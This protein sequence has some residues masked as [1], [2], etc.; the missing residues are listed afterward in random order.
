MKEQAMLV[1]CTVPNA[2]EA[3]SISR[4]LIRKKLAACCNV[5]PGIISI[6]RWEGE[7][8]EENEVLLLIK[9]SLKKYDQVE[10]EI[11]MIH[12]YS[13]PEIIATPVVQ[14]SQAYLDWII[15]MTGE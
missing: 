4:L 1:Y 14:A 9:T 3:K 6:Y 5:I 7:V 10:K 11:K 13:I 8:Q 2:D 12:S 15:Q